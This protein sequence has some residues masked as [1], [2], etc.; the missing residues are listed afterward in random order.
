MPRKKNI[1]TEDYNKVFPQRLRKAMQLHGETQAEVGDAIGKTRQAVGYYADGSSS[2]DWETLAKIAK[3]LG[4]STDWLLGLSNTPAIDDKARSACDFLG[5]SLDSARFLYKN[6][7]NRPIID[8]I[9]FLL[10]EKELVIDISNYFAAFTLKQLNKKPYIYIPLE[11]KPTP[12]LSAVAFAALIEAL[13]KHKDTFK[14][15]FR[16]DDNFMQQT[17]FGYLKRNVDLN[18]C[19]KIIKYYETDWEEV[20]LENEAFYGTEEY[21]EAVDWL[22]EQIAEQDAIEEFEHEEHAQYEA[23]CNFLFALNQ[24]SKNHDESE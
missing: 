13:P 2:P 3:H 4:V 19:S 5:L 16:S 9:N 23:V 8:A 10:E 14:E 7:Q 24:G 22:T 21:R 18:K 15:R 20:A 1:T 11:A 17:V 6:K 12:N